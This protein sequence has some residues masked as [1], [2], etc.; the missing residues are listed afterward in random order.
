MLAL[1]FAVAA[2]QCPEVEAPA[3][4]AWEVFTIRAAGGER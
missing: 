1:R 2:P 3:S 4:V